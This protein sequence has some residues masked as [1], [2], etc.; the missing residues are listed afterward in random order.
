[1][2]FPV[3]NLFVKHNSLSLAII[4]Y[5]R[6]FCYVDKGHG[7]SGS[8]IAA[9]GAVVAGLFLIII[10]IIIVVCVKRSTG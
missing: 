1:M 3:F 7:I 2:Q 4:I 5:T 8:M 10:I 6:V 9:I